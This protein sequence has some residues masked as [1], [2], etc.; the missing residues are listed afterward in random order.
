MKNAPFI[1]SLFV[2]CL[3]LPFSLLS[4]ETKEDQRQGWSSTTLE[5]IRFLPKNDASSSEKCPSCAVSAD[6][7]FLLRT[8]PYFLQKLQ[9]KYI[10][11]E[12]C[13]SLL[14]SLEEDVIDFYHSHSQPFVV[15]SIPKQEFSSGILDVV[16]MEPV[17]GEVLFKG[18]EDSSPEMLKN[19]IAMQSGDP[20][21]GQE[22][23]KKMQRM[24]DNPFRRT[25]AVWKPGVKPGTCDLELN[26]IDRFPYRFYMGADNTGTI[27]TERDRL[28]FGLNF[29]KTIIA[30]SEL[31]YQFT[32]SP[33]WNRF[34]TQTALCKVPFP[35]RQTFIF[36]GGYSQ[37]EPE[38][39][40]GNQE[41]SRAWQVDGRYRIPI[42]TNTLFL[43]EILLG[44]DFKEVISKIRQGGEKK[45]YGVADINQFMAGY[46]VGLKTLNYRLNLVA[47]IYGNPGGITTHNKTKDYEPFRSNAGPG[48]I[49]GK[50]SHSFAYT[51]SN[52][53]FSYDINGQ[54]S[55]K[56]LLPSEQFTLA[57]YNAVRGFE[58]RIVNT[59]NAILINLALQSPTLSIGKMAGWSKEVFD[60]LYFLAFFDYGLGGNHLYGPNE[61]KTQSL[62]SIGPAVRYQI[63]RYVSFRFDYGFQLFH[64]GFH[65]P[66]NSRYNFGLIVSF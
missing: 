20:I 26:T 48:Y 25:D 35:A 60:E 49:Y 28:F 30:D 44:Y 46:D 62:A 22:L 3:A 65:N 2:S 10:G 4:V 45:F 14:E 24:N 38:L 15:V 50:F 47:E 31:S 1:L 9:A 42:I 12:L 61:S 11:K 39:S 6:R 18:N 36:Y 32:C 29:G 56:N 55:S 17:F 34:N 23:L 13:L 43:Q 21:D 59:D 66:T 19:L 51:F 7:V 37:V 41:K 8:N 54:L 58:E 53:R 40:D 63:D 57:G 27:Q 64:H 52:W 33:N 16:V 5:A